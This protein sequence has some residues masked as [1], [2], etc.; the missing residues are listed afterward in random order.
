M[1]PESLGAISALAYPWERPPPQSLL[2]LRAPKAIIFTTGY[3]ADEPALL[4]T[5]ERAPDAA[6]YH[7]T[8]N[9]TIE[10]VSDGRKLWVLTERGT[11]N[12]ER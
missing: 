3:K 1:R 6:I 9:G 11:R 10:L 5:Y 12:E 2:E 8:L 4:T 7:P